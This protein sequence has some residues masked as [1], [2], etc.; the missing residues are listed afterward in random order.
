M[1]SKLIPLIVSISMLFSSTSY[2]QEY[3]LSPEDEEFEVSTG[4]SASLVFPAVP[5]IPKNEPDVGEAISPMKRGQT[6]PF[7]GLLLS[8]AAIATVM[9][10]IE[11][12]DELIRLEVNRA[13]SKLKLVHEHEMT[14]L[15]IRNESDSKIDKLRIEEQRKELDALDAQLK[16]ERENR[17]DPFIWAS[18]GLG[19]GVILTT[20]TAA[21]ITSVSNSN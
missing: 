13:V 2:S 19:A 5:E 14:I 18:I 12:K 20:L 3:S 15:R 4:S 16:R 11:T 8:P 7:T 10:D 21:V 1:K 17:P 9:S 6:A